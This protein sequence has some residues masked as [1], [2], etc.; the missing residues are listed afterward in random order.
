MRDMVQRLS[1]E[2]GLTPQER[3]QL[4]PSGRVPLMRNRV[5]WAT[6][7]LKSGLPWSVVAEHGVEHG[8]KLAHGGSQGDLA[9]VAGRAETLVEGADAGIVA[10]GREGRHV[11]DAA[12]RASTPADH[13]AAPEG[14]AVAIERGEAHPRGDA[15]AIEPAEFG[16]IGDSRLCVGR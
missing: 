1:D 16:E 7:Y 6:T 8:Q 11:Q 13:A 4:L 9:R 3:E 15:A 2:F 12:D 14:A 5:G 10:Y